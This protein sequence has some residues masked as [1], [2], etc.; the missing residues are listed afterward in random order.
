MGQENCKPC[1]F[2]A[3]YSS[4]MR[5]DI[6]TLRRWA[7]TGLVYNRRLKTQGHFPS[8]TGGIF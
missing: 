4:N 6:Q 2:F 1:A 3:P 8:F 5:D 7:D